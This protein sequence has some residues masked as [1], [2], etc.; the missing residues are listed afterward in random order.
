MAL[1]TIQKPSRTGVA[2]TYAAATSGAG[3]DTFVNT[4]REF[5]HVKNDSG[6]S[7]T[8]TVDAP[9][10][11]SFGVT[12]DSHDLSIAIPAGEDRMIGPFPTDRFSDSSNLVKATY[13]DVTSLT[14]A[15]LSVN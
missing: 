9:N 8:V 6:G 11:C 2:V 3:G 14:V 13:S 7:I 1:L 5:L 12:H 10:A 4:G 15:A